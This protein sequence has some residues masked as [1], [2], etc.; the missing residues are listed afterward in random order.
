[1]SQKAFVESVVSRYGVKSLSDLSASH[2]ADFGPRKDD[3][4]T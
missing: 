3:K 4:S 1:M 2:S